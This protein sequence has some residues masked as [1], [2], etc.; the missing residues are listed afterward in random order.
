MPRGNFTEEGNLKKVEELKLN[1]N[2][3]G[4]VSMKMN[5]EQFEIFIKQFPNLEELYNRTVADMLR[6]T[7][8]NEKEIKVIMAS[9][10]LQSLNSAMPKKIVPFRKQGAT[11]VKEMLDNE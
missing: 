6:N 9:Q 1:F 11:Q 4:T 10:I 2:H 8:V 3:D 7:A 5:L